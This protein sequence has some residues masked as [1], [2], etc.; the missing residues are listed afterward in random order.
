M[1]AD[2]GIK[3]LSSFMLGLP[4]ET[5]EDSEQ[6]IEFALKSNLDYALFP[7]TEPYPGTELWIDA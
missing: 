6:T 7:I 2:H 5:K 4:T 3:T 1:A